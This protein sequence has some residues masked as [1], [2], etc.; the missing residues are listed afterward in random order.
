MTKVIIFTTPPLSKT[1]S[2]LSINRLP[3][4]EVEH[5]YMLC[6]SGC[7]QCDNQLTKPETRNSYR[8]QSTVRLPG[9]KACSV[10]S[11]LRVRTHACILREPE[12]CFFDEI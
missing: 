12:I 7:C 2:S 10:W 3:Y 1:D 11:I 5:L 8:S 4:V 6:N 9:R